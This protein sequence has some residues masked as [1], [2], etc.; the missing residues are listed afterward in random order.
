[1]IGAHGYSLHCMR[2]AY[3]KFYIRNLNVCFGNSKV[4]IG[5]HQLS[6]SGSCQGS[7]SKKISLKIS[8]LASNV[9]SQYLPCLAP[10]WPWNRSCCHWEFM[11]LPTDLQ[12]Q[13]HLQSNLKTFSCE[14]FFGLGGHMY[15]LVIMT[16]TSLWLHTLHILTVS[17]HSTVKRLQRW[18]RSTCSCF[19]QRHPSRPFLP[20]LLFPEEQQRVREI[21]I[22]FS[23]QPAR[24]QLSNL[25]SHCCVLVEQPFFPFDTSS[26]ENGFTNWSYDYRRKK[27]FFSP[28][29]M[30][31]CF[32]SLPS[33]L[34]YPGCARE[35]LIFHALGP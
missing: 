4:Q 28:E 20:Q 23:G 10:G 3:H 1:M 15:L 32:C 33:P 14:T 2:T 11:F 35:R 31:P 19:A 16:E 7:W 6:R 18:R 5:Y 9:S 27:K 34:H 30:V 8:A 24:F 29:P 21:E 22:C 17:N 13:H 25:W 12:K 26:D